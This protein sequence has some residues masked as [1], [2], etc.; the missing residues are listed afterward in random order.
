MTLKTIEGT[1]IAPKGRYALVVGRFNSFVVESLVSGAVDA[2]VRHGV[3]ESDITIIRAPGAFE[4]PLVAQKVAQKGEFAAIIALGAVIRGG[5]PHFEYVAG[6]CTKGLAQVSMEFGVPV[7][8]GVLTVDSIEQAIE[9]SGTKAGNK[10][11]E[12]ALSALELVS[13]LA[14]LEAKCLATKAFVSSGAILSLRMPASRR[15]AP[16]VVKPV[17]SRLK[18]CTSGTWPGNR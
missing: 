4:I 5:T 15:R 18:R 8:F 16:S 13:L 3:S 9:R 7:A 11:A 1:F 6:E 10:G 12:A 17:S 14:E 2:L